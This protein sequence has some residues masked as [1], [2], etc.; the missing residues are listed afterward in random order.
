MRPWELGQRERG[1]G[2]EGAEKK[3]GEEDDKKR[4]DHDE[5][6]DRRDEKEECNTSDRMMEGEKEDTGKGKYC[7]SSHTGKEIGELIAASPK[8][9]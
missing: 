7:N 6:A 3:R 1:K 8:H 2:G 4:K 5:E 9:V